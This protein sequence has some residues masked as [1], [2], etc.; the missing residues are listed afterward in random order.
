MALFKQE[1][2][3][4]LCGYDT[5]GF[6]LFQCL[7]MTA[8]G[9]LTLL[10]RTPDLRQAQY[11]SDLVDI[12]CCDREGVNPQVELKAILEEHWPFGRYFGYRTR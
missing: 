12:R 6:S 8:D 10:T 4:Y 11:T 7:V 1:S 2:M 5:F 9:K 3:Y